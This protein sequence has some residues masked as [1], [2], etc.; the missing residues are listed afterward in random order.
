MEPPAAPLAP[1]RARSVR[2]LGIAVLIVLALV[3]SFLFFARR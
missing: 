3:A 2:V 1:A